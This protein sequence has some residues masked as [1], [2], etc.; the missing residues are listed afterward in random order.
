MKLPAPAKVNLHLRIL[1]KR[2]DGFH[3]IETLMVP[4]LL[5]DEITVETSLGRTVRVTCDNP[6]VPMGEHNLAVR[7][8]HE[9]SRQTG[10]QFAARIDIK[11]RIPMGAGLGGGSSDA[12]TVL[13]A[14][15]SIFETRLGVTELQRMAAH[16]GSDVPFFIRRH[17]AWCRGR[18]EI[19]EPFEIPE[20]LPLLLI[21]PAFGVETPWAYKHW[22]AS[23]EM[24][25]DYE[26]EQDLGWVK[27]FNSLERPVFEKFLVLPVMK[28][29]LLAQPEVRVAAMSGSGSTMF[30][31]LK[32]GASGGDLEA[33]VKEHFGPSLWTASCETL[34]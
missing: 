4:V 16:L 11:K 19:I 17:P 18:G 5:S 7:A 14:L 27:V 15:D 28:Q 21:K 25:G 12:A 3:T 31:V 1:G 2:A 10:R 23:H 24:P 6:D 33:R 26:K 34:E 29:W 30:A 32:E 20:K 13:I 9:F 22:S 8:A